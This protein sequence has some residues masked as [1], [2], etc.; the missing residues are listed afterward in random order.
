MAYKTKVR[1]I[2][3]SLGIVLPKEALHALKVEEGATL[4]LTEA[5]EG[6]LSVNP[7]RPGFED[8]MT[9]AEEAMNRYRNTLRELAK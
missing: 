2:G 3:N 6:T 1:K 9:I 7:E 5:P 4:Y 8:I